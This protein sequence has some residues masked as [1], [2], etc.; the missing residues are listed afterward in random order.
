MQIQTN[1]SI[2]RPI[3]I[4]ANKTPITSNKNLILGDLT[5]KRRDKESSWRYSYNKGNKSGTITASMTPSQSQITKGFPKKKQTDSMHHYMPM[6]IPQRKGHKVHPNSITQRNFN[7]RSTYSNLADS[8]QT[9]STHEQQALAAH[10]KNLKLPDI[11][12]FANKTQTEGFTGRHKPLRAFNLSSLQPAQQNERDSTIDYGD[13]SN[14]TA[15]EIAG[16]SHHRND[17][18]EAS[19]TVQS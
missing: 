1:P 9:K 17:N 15:S 19:L 12:K 8:L 2:Q 5:N 7:K 18:K 11:R 6:E 13:N 16:N 4:G 10:Q 3:N 14:I